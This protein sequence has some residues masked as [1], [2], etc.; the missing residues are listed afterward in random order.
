MIGAK[1][2]YKY[3]KL[4]FLTSNDDHVKKIK[5]TNYDRYD[6]RDALKNFLDSIYVRYKLDVDEDMESIESHPTLR[7][8]FVAGQSS[9][10]C[11]INTAMKTFVIK[12]QKLTGTD[13][14]GVNDPRPRL[15]I[16]NRNS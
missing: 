2:K 3:Y 5:F 6:R 7:N 16:E 1:R 10:G 13:I 14:R 15:L 9:Y 4:P 11:M 8:I 12:D